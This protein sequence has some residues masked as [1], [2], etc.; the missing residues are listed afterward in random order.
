MSS[1]YVPYATTP[2]RLLAQ[3][4]SDVVVVLWTIVWV[5]VGLAVHS[6]VSTIADGGQAGERRRH[7]CLGQPE[8]RR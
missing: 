5:F 7:R 2:G 4:T 1:R 6:A 3:L 8:L